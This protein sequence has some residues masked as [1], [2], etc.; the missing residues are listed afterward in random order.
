MPS[1]STSNSEFG[2]LVRRAGFFLAGLALLYTASLWVLSELPAPG[3]QTNQYSLYQFAA[4]DLTLPGGYGY[5]LTRFREIEQHHDVD[6]LFVGSSRCYYSFSP[7]VFERLGVSTFNMGSPSQT[8]LNSYYLLKK[9]YDHLA[10]KLVVFEINPHV[11]QKDGVESFLDLMINQPVSPEIV[12]MGLATRDPYALNTLGV[13]LLNALHEDFDTVRMQPRPMDE[14]LPGGAV[15]AKNFNEQTFDETP[16]A[17][18]IPDNQL[19]YLKKIVDLVQSRGGRIL[20]VVAPVPQEWTGVIT[21]YAETMAPLRTLAK[22]S[23]VRLYDFSEAMTLDSKIFFKDFHHL[24]ANGA[25][26]F[27]YDVVDSLLDVPEYRDA[28]H[29][30][31][32]LAAEVYNGRGIAFAQQ[33]DLGRAINDY[34]QALELAPDNGMVAYNLARACEQAGL[35][36]DAIAAYRSFITHAD[37]EHHQLVEP[38]KM[39]LAALEE[40]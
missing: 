8:P 12:E 11:L 2:K 35:R 21:N 17:V 38:V 29:I 31:P 22:T 25:K 6:L 40:Q 19:T 4:R 14:Y 16:F 36:D 18:D 39:H 30:E 23:N 28:L 27:S 7:Q 10:P 32:T 24:N 15:S 5:T 34:K 20:L 9:Y 13:R 33:G 3:D 1:S 37:G 26:I